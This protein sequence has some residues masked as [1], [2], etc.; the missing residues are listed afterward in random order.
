MLR[1][2]LCLCFIVMSVGFAAPRA[3]AASDRVSFLRGIVVNDTEEAQ[4]V[5]CFLCSIRVDGKV[6]GDAVAF[7]G[8]IHMKGEIRGDV[9]TFLGEV[10]MGDESRI[11]GDCV[12]FGAPLHR[13]SDATI[14]GDTVQI[15]FIVIMLP[16]IILAL[17]IY[18]L[19]MLLR[20][21]RYA[22]YPMPPPMR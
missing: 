15:P 22:A 6:S 7:L 9:V 13:S 17:L 11:G 3:H 21:R 4:D 16:F 8:G 19:V 20:R 5:V 10:A 1:R 2:F 18:G 14:R 12:V